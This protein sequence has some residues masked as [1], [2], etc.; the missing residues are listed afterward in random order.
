M[1]VAH[2]SFSELRIYLF[3]NQHNFIKYLFLEAEQAP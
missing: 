2:D 3:G 1:N